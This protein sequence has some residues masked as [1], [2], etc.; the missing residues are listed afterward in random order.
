MALLPQSY[1]TAA[2]ENEFRR[3]NQRIDDLKTLLTFI[4]QTDP[5]ANPRIGMIMY[6]DGTSTT[7]AGH[8]GR[9]LYRYDYLDPDVNGDV[10]WIHFASDDMVPAV[11]VGDSGDV[12]NYDKSNDFAMLTNLN[13]GSWTLNLPSPVTQAYRTI[14]FVSDETTSGA[15]KIVLDAGSFF[16][17]PPGGSPSGSVSTFDIDRKYEGV[18]IFSDGTQW[19][20]I[21]KSG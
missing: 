7:F 16:I 5:V 10:G 15:S 8:R 3:L 12:I 20:V 21:Q 13:G 4:P 14:K 1:D 9:G 19:I 11:V 2:I 6:S 18:T 17:Q